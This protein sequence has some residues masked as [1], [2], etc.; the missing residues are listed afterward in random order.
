MTQALEN[1]I[2]RLNEHIKELKEN[3]GRYL[4]ERHDQGRHFIDIVVNDIPADLPLREA[5]RHI[6][7]KI[8]P[9]YQPYQ[10]HAAYRSKRY[11]WVATFLKQESI[12]MTYKAESEN[13]LVNR[14]LDSIQWEVLDLARYWEKT[15]REE[16][17]QASEEKQEKG[18]RL[19]EGINELFKVT[20]TN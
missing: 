19:M 7:N 11:G 5:L 15:L 13:D 18:L 2:H 20:Q 17:P 8:L 16:I 4:K 9:A 14:T 10:Y 6:K 1:E 12:N 3:V